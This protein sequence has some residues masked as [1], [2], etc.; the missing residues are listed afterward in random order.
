MAA[1]YEVKATK[2]GFNFNLKAPNG[3]YV[4]TSETYADQR[5]ALKG[6]ESVRKNCADAKAYEL[7]KSKKDEPYFVLLAKNKEIIGKSEMYKTLKGCRN[8]ISSC[9]KFGPEA[10]VEQ[11][12]S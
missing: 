9:M 10:R 7:R 12:A 11:V 2:S 4:L 5:A 8:G 3:K 1:K 6:V